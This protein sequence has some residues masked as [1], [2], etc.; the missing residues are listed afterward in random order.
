MSEFLLI[1]TS[2]VVAAAIVI[3]LIRSSIRARRQLITAMESQA[4]KQREFIQKLSEITA[5]FDSTSAD[6]EPPRQ[7]VG[8][9]KAVRFPTETEW[10]WNQR[11]RDYYLGTYQSNVRWRNF[12]EKMCIVEAGQ[13]YSTAAAHYL[14][15]EESGYTGARPPQRF[16]RLGGAYED[17]VQD[18]LEETA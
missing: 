13:K 6:A 9:W 18:V 14:H 11:P 8:V 15:F 12:F 4:I 10:H 2:F 17:D 5:M 3:A 16:T 7:I 1:T